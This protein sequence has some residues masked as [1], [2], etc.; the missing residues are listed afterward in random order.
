MCLEE[1]TSKPP[2]SL[3][4]FPLISRALNIRSGGLISVTL[5]GAFDL[6]TY[7]EKRLCFPY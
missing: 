1:A 3:H 4:V 7:C 5:N 2:G 6:G